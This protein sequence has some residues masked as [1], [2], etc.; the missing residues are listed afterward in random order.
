LGGKLT[1][2]VI[3]LG[4]AFIYFGFNLGYDVFFD[5][6]AYLRRSIR[7]TDFYSKF[8]IFNWWIDF[9]RGF[10]QIEIAFTLFFSAICLISGVLMI[11][12]GFQG[13]INVHW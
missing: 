2:M 8:F 5:R 11:F 3:I 1:I 12:V 4:L 13:P 6:Q 10:P 7:Y 9:I